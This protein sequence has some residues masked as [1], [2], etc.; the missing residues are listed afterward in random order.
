MLHSTR[1]IVIHTIKYAETSIIARIFTEQFGLQSYLIKGIR[2]AKARLK[3]GLFQPLNILDLVVYHKQK[4]TLQNIREANYL[5]P[6][7]S[8]PFDIRKSSI[9]LFINELI[10]KTIHEEEA[11]QELFD[12]LLRTCV[13]LDESQSPANWFHLVF[14]L[15]FTRFLGFMPQQNHSPGKNIFNLKEGFFQESIPDHPYY[16][17]KPQSELFSR[18]LDNLDNSPEDIVIPSKIRDLILEKIL[19]YY[20]LHFPGFTGMKSH[21]VLHTV[22]S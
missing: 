1:G 12:F 7:Q 16:L 6:Y 2:Q 22:L 13:E 5:F 14:A 17:D 20:Q 3:P 4:S 10:H 15:R 9:A 8:I 21:L 11:N 19:V 18:L